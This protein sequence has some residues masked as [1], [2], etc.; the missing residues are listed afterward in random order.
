[1]LPRAIALMLVLAPVSA[2]AESSGGRVVGTSL[3]ADVACVSSIDVVADPT[4]ANEVVYSVT[5][6]SQSELDQLSIQGG[7]VVRLATVSGAK[8]YLGGGSLAGFGAMIDDLLGSG[9]VPSIASMRLDLRV[10]VGMPVRVKLS[11]SGEIAVGETRGPLALD[12]AGASSARATAVGALDVSIAGTG[13]VDVGTIDGDAR[14]SVAGNGSIG[15]ASGR[16]GS[17]WVRIAGSGTVKVGADVADAD[18]TILGT[19]SIDVAKAT[20]DVQRNVSG[21]GRISI[22]NRP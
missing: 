22:G 17:L 20:G 7:A 6:G 5:A 10:P 1:M 8:C 16:V 14:V 11:G 4:L 12:L 15:I 9:R 13:R 21:I 19:G 18:L 2:Y 3:E